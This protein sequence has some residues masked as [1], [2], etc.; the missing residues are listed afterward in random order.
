MYSVLGVQELELEFWISNRGSG[1]KRRV[2]V[3]RGRE[4]A[5]QK[6]KGTKKK[7]VVSRAEE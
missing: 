3:R 7:G 1:K 4:S 5:N 6:K 2:S